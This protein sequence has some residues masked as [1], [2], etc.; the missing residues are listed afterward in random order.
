[1]A[2]AL[3]Q[4]VSNR[5]GTDATSYNTASITPTANALLL[6]FIETSQGGGTAG[7]PTLSGN[8]LTWVEILAVTYS[9]SIKR[10]SV[11][12][13]MGASPSA[14]AVTITSN[15]DT[16]THGAWKVVELTGVD[17][18]GT[19]GSGAIVQAVA[20]TPTT[21][22][23]PSVT[24]AAFADATNNAAVG[25]FALSNNSTT[26]APG[27]TNEIGSEQAI[28]SPNGTLA[29]EWQIGEALSVGGTWGVSADTAGIA[30]EI[31]AAVLA[32]K[33][34]PLFSRSLQSF[35]RSF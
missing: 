7:S 26:F 29:A 24:L 11:F 1:M 17:T 4:L 34:A 2:I 12:R 21:T 25:A 22:T 8:G 15:G 13:A 18:S 35:R 10:L 28:I 33:A 20:G 6:A 19:N 16:F 14:G 32:T 31:K 3:T 23:T 30:L 9:G 5:S 27:L